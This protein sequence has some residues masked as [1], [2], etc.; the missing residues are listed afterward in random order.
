MSQATNI[1][2]STNF[3][4]K[5]SILFSQDGEHRLVFTRLSH[6]LS[7]ALFGDINFKFL[8][9]FGNTAL[10]AL[11]FLFLKTIKVPHATLL[12]FIPISILLFQLQSWKNMIWAQAA[13]QHQYIL[14]FT[15]LTF[16]FLGKYSNRSFYSAFFFAVVSVFTHGSGLATIFIGWVALLISKRYRQS[17]V[18]AVGAFILGLFYF[19]NYLHP[20][21]N[22]FAWT[23][24]LAG[25]KNLLMYFFSYLGSSISLN[26]MPVAVG[27]GVVLSFYLCFLTKDKYFERNLTVY[28]HGT[29]FF[30]CRPSGNRP[31]GFGT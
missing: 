26:E 5:L 27:F 13:L 30:S 28:F 20:L 2:Q 7:Y 12:S 29:H 10:V 11:F 19:K 22:V 9:I 3:S 16:Y 14:V 8:V 21:H 1:M 25:L 17:A 6:I 24:S 4:E 15:G 23:Q 31:L 18:W